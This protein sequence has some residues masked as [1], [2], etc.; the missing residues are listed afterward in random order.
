LKARRRGVAAARRSALSM[1]A[2]WLPPPRAPPA[3]AAPARGRGAAAAAGSPTR[4]CGGRARNGPRLS[5]TPAGGPHPRRAPARQARVARPRMSLA[6]CGASA[7]HRRADVA[8][9]SR[10]R[11]AS[12]QRPA[13]RR[14]ALQPPL[15]L[16]RHVAGWLKKAEEKAAPA[17]P[18]AGSSDTPQ[19]PPPAAQRPL[20]RALRLLRPLLPR[21]PLVSYESGCALE[22]P[23]QARPSRRCR[24]GSQRLIHLLPFLRCLRSGK[25]LASHRAAPR[26]SAS[27]PR[28][29]TASHA[30]QH[31]QPQTRRRRC[32]LMKRHLTTTPLAPPRRRDACSWVSRAPCR[33]VITLAVGTSCSVFATS[34][35]VLADPADAS[36]PPVL[37]LY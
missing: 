36:L 9:L 30:S 4:S 28:C 15:A 27:P 1:L 22:D 26:P 7:A 35:S 10:G 12:S 16:H 20:D 21:A 37:V 32:L 5:A 18:P 17:Q 2:A 29:A 13:P 6:A 25:L 19:T 3:A 11:G 23:A 34:C 24:G 14:T 8:Q 33:C 31:T